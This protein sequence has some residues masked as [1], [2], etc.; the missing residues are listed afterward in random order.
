M[1]TCFY[2]ATIKKTAKYNFVSVNICDTQ[3]IYIKNIQECSD[4][5]NCFLAKYADDYQFITFPK[6]DVQIQNLLSLIMTT[7][8]PAGVYSIQ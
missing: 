2:L 7:K 3:L 4:E 8:K 5:E 1:S 6:M